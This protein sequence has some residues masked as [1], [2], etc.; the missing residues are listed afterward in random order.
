MNKL[1]GGGLIVA[2]LILIFLGIVLKTD[3][4]AGLIAFTGWV[5]IVVGIILGVIGIIKFLKSSSG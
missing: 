2:A 3:I 5:L 1:G 4:I